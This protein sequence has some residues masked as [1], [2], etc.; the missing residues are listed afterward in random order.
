MIDCVQ[1]VYFRRKL[2][3]TFPILNSI[4]IV[5]FLFC[6]SL[7]KPFKY[8]FKSI[9]L[10]KHPIWASRKF[11]APVLYRTKVS[12]WFYLNLLHLP[13]QTLLSSLTLVSSALH[14]G[15]W[16]GWIS[17]WAWIHFSNKSFHGTGLYAVSV[18]Y[19]MTRVFTSPLTQNPRKKYG[20]I[21]I[22]E[23]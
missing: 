15:F 11:S 12:Y 1:F 17:N 19:E 21:D 18:V 9:Q 20:K 23:K 13:E 3:F 8:I 10:T 7:C 4:F 22:Q 14:W 6:K 16:P 5:I 2:T